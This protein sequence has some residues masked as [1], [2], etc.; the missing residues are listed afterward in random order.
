MK[1]LGRLVIVIWTII[2]IVLVSCGGFILFPLLSYIFTG[3]DPMESLGN[4]W[5]IGKDGIEDFFDN[6]NIHNN[7]NG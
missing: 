1:A 4:I 3:D 5:E 7:F 2:Y 6:I